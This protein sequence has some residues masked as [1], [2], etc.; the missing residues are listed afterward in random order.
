M[1]ARQERLAAPARLRASGTAVIVEGELLLVTLIF[2]PVDIAFVMILDHHLPCPD[3]LAMP[4]APPRPSVDNGGALLTF[5][6]NVDPGVEGILEN[7]DHIAVA[8]RRPVEARHA[9][10]IGGPWE[11]DLIGFHREQNLARAA[12]FTEAGE[13]EAND[14]LET[15]DRDQGQALLP[16][17]RCSRREPTSAARPGWPSDRAASNI[18]RAQHAEFELADAAFHAKE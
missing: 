8:D 7:R 11:V 14:L 13:D 16:G 18:L 5:P 3:R 9:A 4:V 2:R 10:L 6:V 1:I 15:S 17:A 12:E